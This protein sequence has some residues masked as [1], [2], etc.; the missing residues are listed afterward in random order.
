[1]ISTQIESNNEKFSISINLK[2]SGKKR[3]RII[4]SDAGRQNSNYADRTINVDKARSIYFNLPV[5]PK[6]L[7]LSIVNID[8][9]NDKD[10]EVTTIKTDLRSYNIWI[11]EPTEKFLKLSIPFAQVC[12]FEH[13]TPNGRIFTNKNK[14]YTIKYFDIIRDYKTGRYL[15]TPARIG[16]Q[17]GNIEV[18]KEK[19]DKYTIPMRI[20]LHEYSHVY[21]NPKI[22]LQI[23]DEVGAD[24][25]ALYIYSGL[26]FSKIDAI[27]VYANVFLKAQTQ[28]NIKRMRKIMDYIA[29]FENQDFAYRN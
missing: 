27:C 8:N 7:T 11:D 26:G 24:I 15:N 28:G 23:D 12:G 10:I 6:S 2:T 18:S 13:A 20:L 1:M 9:V 3:L 19:F 4:L 16:H 22:G 14:T 21:R 25:N 17:T 29:K 5:S